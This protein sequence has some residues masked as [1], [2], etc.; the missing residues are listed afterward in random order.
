ME[1]ASSESNTFIRPFL[2]GIEA[3]SILIDVT[4][5][6]D[7]QLLRNAMQAFKKDDDGYED[8][9]GRLTVVGKYLGRSFIET[10][11][12]LGS[13]GYQAVLNGITLEDGTVVKGFLAILLMPPLLK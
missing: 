8:Y 7:P 3:N 5:L 9:L 10:L 1:E 6:S 12:T 2:K 13:T 11:W 4:D